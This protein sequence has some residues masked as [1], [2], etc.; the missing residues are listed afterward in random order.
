MRYETLPFERIRNLR[1]DAD[2]TQET[3]AQVLDIK[4]NTYSQYELGVLRYPIEAL[5]R[6]A[7]FYNTSIDYLVGLTDEPKPYERKP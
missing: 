6:L 3:V 7:L 4:Q 5:I 2:L 1:V